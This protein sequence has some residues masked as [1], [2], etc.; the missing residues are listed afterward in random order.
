[1]TL[2]P[3]KAGILFNNLWFRRHQI[4]ELFYFNIHENSHSSK[5]RTPKR[6]INTLLLSSQLCL[7]SV[8]A[9]GQVSQE[10]EWR[11]SPFLFLPPSLFNSGNVNYHPLVIHLR[12]ST[13]FNTAFLAQLLWRT[14]KSVRF[15][16]ICKLRSYL[17]TILW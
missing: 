15:Y 12:N 1:V 16:P 11:T 13:D 14:V 4:T 5:R 7:H 8:R 6:H 10:Q 9:Y 3:Q 17:A 2:Q